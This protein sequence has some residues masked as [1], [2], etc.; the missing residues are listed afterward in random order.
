MRQISYF[1][2]VILICFLLNLS[3]VFPANWAQTSGKISQNIVIPYYPAPGKPHWSQ[4]YGHV[5]I[6]VPAPDV[7]S[8]AY[9]FV[10]GGDSYSNRDGAADLL[11]GQFDRKW[12]NGYKNDVWR[13]T[14]ID[15]D[16]RQNKRMKSQYGRKIPE[17]KSK[18]QWEVVTNGI[19]PQWD[20]LMMIG[21]HAIEQN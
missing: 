18:L 17:V 3:K 13:T 14:G 1:T 10:L 9:M 12:E 21:Y 8:L 15:W 20:N 19:H 6:T 11:P 2:T 7:E 4:R 16:V 5:T